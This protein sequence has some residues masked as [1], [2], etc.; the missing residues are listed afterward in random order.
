MGDSASPKIM[1]ELLRDPDI[2]LF[3]V[4]QADAYVRRLTYLNKL[5][6]PKGS[7]DFGKNIPS[8]DVTLI[9]PTVDLIARKELHPALSDLLLEAAHEVH[10]PA[11][12]LRRQGEFPAALE[13]DFPLSPEAGRYYK[14]GKSFTYRYLPFRLASIVN[15]FLVAFLPVAVVLIPGMRVIPALLRLRMRFRLF[16][17]YRAL[18]AVERDLLRPNEAVNRGDLTTRLAQIEEAVNKM[19]VPASFADQFYVLRQNILF[20]RSRL[21]KPGAP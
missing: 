18:M 9:G 6:L 10:S 20:V 19:K 11:N 1:G 4:I 5:C 15:R 7:L 3:D 12:L 2:Q 17:W 16:R 8:R 21:L 13:H 14:T